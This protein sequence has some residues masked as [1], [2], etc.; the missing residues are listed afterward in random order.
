MIYSLTPVK[1][2]DY[3]FKT[4]GLLNNHLSISCFGIHSGCHFVANKGMELSRTVNHPV[5]IKIKASR[6]GF[7]VARFLILLGK[8]I[9]YFP[10]P[11]DEGNNNCV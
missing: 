5:A 3:C 8:H 9:S 4:L 6:Y 1:F 10:V 2:F 7:R 11:S